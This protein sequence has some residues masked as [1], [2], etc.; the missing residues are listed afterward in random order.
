MPWTSFV[1][2]SV[3]SFT[4][5]SIDFVQYSS[6]SP[7]YKCYLHLRRSNVVDSFDFGMIKTSKSIIKK[8]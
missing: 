3:F 4:H 2:V 7:I 6:L 8:I 1:S 5:Y